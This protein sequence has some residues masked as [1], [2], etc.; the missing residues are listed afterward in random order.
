MQGDH[1]IPVEFGDWPG[2]IV[3]GTGAV[4]R[5]K[6][7]V[8]RL[9]ARRALVVCG[10]TAA[11]GPLLAK[12]QAGLGPV[13]A[14]TFTEVA[15]HTP[16]DMVE[17]GVARVH[18]LNADVLVSLGGGSAIDAAKAIAIML[19]T[20]GDLLPY[21][22]H[23]EPGGEMIRKDV[24]DN[25]IPHIAV[26]TTAGSASDVM[27]TAGCRDPQSRKKL[28]FW[29]HKL[30]PQVTVL[31]PEMAIYADAKLTA[32]TGMTAVARCIEALY[33][34]HRHPISTGLSLHALRLMMQALPRSIAA[35]DDL[36]A[37]AACQMGA[38][39]SGMAAINAMVSV[40]HAVGHVVGG[41]YA[42]QHG[43]SHAILLAPAMRCL[44]PV[45]GDQQ[46]LVLHAL[47]HAPPKDAADV[48]A[49]FV[50]HL[51]LPYRLREL[52]VREDELAEMARLTTSDYMMANLPRPMPEAEVLA[53][54]REA[55]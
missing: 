3:Y 1:V 29:D 6:D 13:L 2:R 51:P 48:M 28:L 43:L 39:M 53:L 16:V 45:I 22:I 55:W 21:A 37:R 35:P 50:G 14:G 23:Y 42:V 30:V 47:G 5:L 4:G 9:G 38:V 46:R 24:P 27:P 25:V 33:S 19:A 12:V 17:R 18:E 8:F 34:R 32:A 49:D 20:G 31:D 44:L 15:A 7:E 26:P 40:V 10:S 54:L 52:G 41:R 36:E 11:H